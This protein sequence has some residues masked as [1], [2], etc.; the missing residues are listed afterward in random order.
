MPLNRDAASDINAGTP[1]WFSADC[2]FHARYF[3]P[4]F[5]YHAMKPSTWERHHITLTMSRRVFIAIDIS[6]VWFWFWKLI[7][8]YAFWCIARML[9][10]ETTASAGALSWC[11]ILH[12]P[13]YSIDI[14][15][16][17]PG[18]ARFWERFFI[19]S[20]NNSDRWQIAVATSAR[21]YSSCMPDC[22]IIISTSCRSTTA[23]FLSFPWIFTR[24]LLHQR[25][26]CRRNSGLRRQVF[27]PLI[28]SAFVAQ[29]ISGVSSIWRIVSYAF[30]YARPNFTACLLAVKLYGNL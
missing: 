14:F 19:F 9:T 10:R 4:H 21:R 1:W 20:V 11:S 7:R 18:N 28:I 13:L 24:W 15:Q 27:I 5:P 23:Q 6:F 17:A 22:V 12:Q 29:S 8:S 25:I 16:E 3:S 30:I 26:L 2:H